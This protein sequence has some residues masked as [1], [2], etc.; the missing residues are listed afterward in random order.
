[1]GRH[2]LLG[3]ISRSQFLIFLDPA[4]TST[5]T[6]TTTSFSFSFSSSFCILLLLLL[7]LPQPLPLFYPTIQPPCSPPLVPLLSPFPPQLFPC[8]AL[9]SPHSTPLF[10]QFNPPLMSPFPAYFP[11]RSPQGQRR[12]KEGEKV[13]P[14]QNQNRWETIRKLVLNIDMHNLNLFEDRCRNRQMGRWW[15]VEIERDLWIER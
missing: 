6:S 8:F 1:M 4:T 14:P 12:G 11:F 7:A 10:P 2:G 15:K 3:L 5:S 13:G 9:L